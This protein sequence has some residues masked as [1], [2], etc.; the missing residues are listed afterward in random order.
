MTAHKTA[1][2]TTPRRSGPNRGSNRVRGI[3]E[4]LGRKIV[5]GTYPPE[6]TLPIEPEL[7]EALGVGRTALREA[8]KV[9]SGKNLL[10]TG[11]RS[12]TK[13]LPPENWNTLD[14]DVIQWSMASPE[15]A[16]SFLTDLTEMRLVIEPA[17]AALAAERATR[18]EAAEL[19]ATIEEMEEAIG[20]EEQSLIADLEFHRLLMKASHNAILAHFGNALATLLRADFE[21][22]MQRHHAYEDN[23]QLHAD[24]AAAVV[25]GKPAEARAA[26]LQLINA[27]R[28]DLGA[29]MSGEANED[30]Q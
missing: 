2:K 11:R 24:V 9:L 3:V 12:G 28:K 29:V 18:R 22:A 19:L 17:A 6:E 1:K 16:E 14:P 26:V 30:P 21:I 7:A 27:N 10:D 5:D 13:V 20:D 15:H 8:I 4:V 25:D 23:L